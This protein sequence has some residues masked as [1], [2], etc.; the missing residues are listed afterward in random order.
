[1]SGRKKL[2]AS[3]SGT[4]R[5]YRVGEIP[6]PTPAHVDRWIRQFD[7]R[8]QMPVLRELDHVL[9]QTYS[10]RD[11]VE[12]FLASLLRSEKLAGSDPRNFWRQ[13]NFFRRQGHGAS[14]EE[15]LTLLDE[16][17]RRKWGFSTAECG[18]PGGSFVYLDDGLFSNDRVFQDLKRW[19]GE[20]APPS[21]RVHVIVLVS[22]SLG[23]FGLGRRV[24]ACALEHCKEVELKI[25]RARR[26]ENRKRYRKDSDVLWPTE[27][28]DDA[29]VRSYQERPGVG[30]I[31]W[32]PPGG[33][34]DLFS[35]ESGRSLLEREFLI[36]GARLVAKAQSPNPLMRPLGYSRFGFG[37]GSMMATFRNCANNAPLA[38]WWG[39]PTKPPSHPLHWYP[40]LPR[41]IHP[42][43]TFGR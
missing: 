29:A 18:E 39:D 21:G 23:E 19:M 26:V 32:R 20:T 7:S 9:K 11:S 43:E 2:L 16:A 27:A 34:T 10:S 42:T 40:L 41:K 33:E 17:F 6:E 28:P 3:L 30:E 38:L 13:A 36:A 24:K 14:Q 15:L 37:F 12:R 25:W 5:D 35:S 8:V 22:H 4:I 1:M 31:A